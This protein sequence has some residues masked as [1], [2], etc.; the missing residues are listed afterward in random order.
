MIHKL[1]CHVPMQVL[2]DVQFNPVGNVLASASGDTTTKFW[3]RPRLNN[4][5]IEREQN[6]AALEQ[7]EGIDQSRE[8]AGQGF[9]SLPA[10][11]ASSVQ[12]AAQAIVAAA[13]AQRQ[14]GQKAGTG[15]PP[16]S[17]R[18]RPGMFVGCVIH[19]GIFINDCPQ[20]A[21]PPPSMC[22]TCVALVAIGS[23]TARCKGGNVD[24]PY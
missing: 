22:V 9:A 2:Y 4:H 23:A 18:H 6:M 14:S 21:A 17:R 8:N 3:C 1:L 7:A 13:N 10:S 16:T 20:R 24:K 11:S 15:I 19:L 12:A 5:K